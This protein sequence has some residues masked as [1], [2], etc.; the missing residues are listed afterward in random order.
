MHQ[1][2]SNTVEMMSYAWNPLKSTGI[3]RNPPGIPGIPGVRGVR[4]EY[5]G[6]CKTLAVP[7][8][9]DDHMKEGTDSEMQ[10]LV[11]RLTDA[12]VDLSLLVLRVFRLHTSHFMA[13]NGLLTFFQGQPLA[14]KAVHIRLLAV[15]PLEPLV[16]EWEPVLHRTFKISPR[17]TAHASNIK[18]IICVRKLPNVKSH[19]LAP[20][21]NTFD[22]D[23]K[24][25][26]C[27]ATAV[28]CE[29]ALAYLIINFG[30]AISKSNTDF[31]WFK[32]CFLVFLSLM[33]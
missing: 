3:H 30:D 21:S 11:G 33:I 6:D 1:T 25:L 14:N 8:P 2:S 16:A 20:F 9:A 10:A 27:C 22:R 12:A 26:M 24:N 4:P 5:M 15:Q 18:T 29:I 13:L 7:D 19:H 31:D 28:H 23:S 32:V 17:L